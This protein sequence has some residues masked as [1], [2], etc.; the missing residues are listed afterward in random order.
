MQNDEEYADAGPGSEDFIDDNDMDIDDESFS[1]AESSATGRRRSSR[2]TVLNS[3]K[4]PSDASSTRS[5]AGGLNGYRGERRSTRLGNAP[6]I[7]FDESEQAL[8]PPAAKRAKTSPEAAGAPAATT[9]TATVAAIPPP[10]GKKKSKFWFYA[11]EPVPGGTNGTTSGTSTPVP[12]TP[13]AS[14]NELA[15]NG[16]P[17]RSNGHDANGVSHSAAPS[18][19]GTSLIDGMEGVELTDGL[20]A[21]ERSAKESVNGHA[22]NGRADIPIVLALPNETKS[23]VIS[24][25]DVS[26]D[27]GL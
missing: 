23:A 10:P 13:G 2:A 19:A 5:G 3:R 9:S 14:H 4:R 25:M 24:N 21:M 27:G 26:S 15:P 6:A 16:T 12:S 8:L 7:A 22:E 1:L 20:Q 17:P 11:L 18:E